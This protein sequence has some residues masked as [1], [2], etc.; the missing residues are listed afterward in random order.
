M[1]RP[2]LSDAQLIEARVRILA[3]AG[4]II[5][6]DGYAALSMRRL[7]SAV[8]LTAG[9]L[10]RY[11]PSKQHVLLAYCVEA[12]DQL[13]RAFERIL[14]EEADGLR[15]LE[16]MLIAYGDFALDDADRFRILFIDREVTKLKLDGARGLES[17]W[18]IQDTVERVQADG[19]LRQLPTTDIV[20]V[21]LAGVHGICV[22]AFT[23]REIDFSDARALVREC[24]CVS[25]RGLS[26]NEE[27]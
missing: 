8:G 17:Y 13:T 10:Y 5:S 1:P 22:L 11:F 25:L 19:R 21:L 27:T 6:A 16:R 26:W 24:A 18:L 12:L 9:A 15:A 2:A 20:R 3:E 4:H 7:A 23:V 14:D